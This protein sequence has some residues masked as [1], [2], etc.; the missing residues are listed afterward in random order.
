[1][2]YTVRSGDTLSAIARR[3]GT[4]AAAIAQANKLDNP[5][6]IRVG[7]G[8]VV[9]AAG[10]EERQAGLKLAAKFIAPEEGLRLAP[11]FDVAG[12]VTRGYGNKLEETQYRLDEMT[13]EQKRAVLARHPRVTRA[14]ALRNF[15][16]NLRRYYEP[17]AAAFPAFRP[18]QLAALTSLAYNVGVAGF[19]RSRLKRL[20]ERGAPTEEVRA[21]WLSWDKVTD[22]DTKELVV[23][24]GLLKRRRQEFELFSGA[25]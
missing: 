7:Q 15:E 12:Y 22:P 16:K 18:A 3:H 14:E 23:S 25:A 13:E 11:Y 20:L 19:A 21:E 10:G 24:P 17:V 9:P 4:T 5:D 6:K 2:R 1:M 8:L